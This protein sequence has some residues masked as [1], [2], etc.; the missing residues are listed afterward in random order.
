MARTIRNR[1]SR[2]GRDCS[3]TWA[4]LGYEVETDAEIAFSARRDWHKATSY[5]Y[6]SSKPCGWKEQ[7]G[8][9]LRKFW[10]REFNR[11]RRRQKIDID[12]E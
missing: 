12:I 7:L 9:R 2:L 8:G 11:A 3:S 1:L 4:G 6:P 10:K 5:V